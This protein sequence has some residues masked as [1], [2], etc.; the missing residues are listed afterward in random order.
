MGSRLR[1][2]GSGGVTGQV[3]WV[4][5]VGRDLFDEDSITFLLRVDF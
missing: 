1:Y 5:T 4:T 3:E 2:F